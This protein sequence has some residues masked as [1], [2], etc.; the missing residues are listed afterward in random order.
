MQAVAQQRAGIRQLRLD[1]FDQL[2]EQ[3]LLQ[4]QAFV[5]GAMYLG[6]L[7]DMQ[8]MQLGTF[9]QQLPSA[10]HSARGAAGEI[11]CSH[12][13][14]IRGVRRGY[15]QQQRRPAFQHDAL[16]RGAGESLARPLVMAAQHQQIGL[17]PLGLGEDLL[18]RLPAAN[19]GFELTQPVLLQALLQECACLL[20]VAPGVALVEYV[21]QADASAGLARQ[22]GGTLQREIGVRA[23]IV[24]DKNVLN[25]I[26]LKHGRPREAG[27]RRKYAVAAGACPAHDPR[28]WVDRAQQLHGQWPLVLLS[29]RSC[30]Y[31]CRH[32]S[33]S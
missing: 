7:V 29:I 20:F 17:Q 2:V 16:Q 18:H 31:A 26:V 23:E 28:R 11:Q 8:G 3:L 1:I 13:A 21:K 15:G 22:T 19:P 5:I 10:V 24:G 30:G 6:H 27:E 9:A 32:S 33:R 4:R 12:G 14:M 25:P